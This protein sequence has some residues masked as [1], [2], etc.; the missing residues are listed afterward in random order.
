[1]ATT[2][3]EPFVVPITVAILVGLFLVQPFG[4]G[5]VGVFFGPVLALWFVTIAIL[6]VKGILEGPEV[7]AAFNPVRGIR[8]FAETGGRGFLVLGAVV[9]CLTGGEAL[10][11]DMGHFGARAIR[12]AWFALALPSLVLNYLGQGAVLLRRPE[13]VEN[14]FFFMAPG[15]ALYPLVALAAAATVIAS[16]ALISAVF[17]L[18]R[19]AMQLDFSPR[20]KI[21]HTSAEE[22][23]QIYLPGLNW[24]LMLATI[25]LVVGFGS[26]SRLAAAFGL[27]VAGTMGV[28]TALFAYVMRAH[29]RWPWAAVGVFVAVFLTIDLAFLGANGMKLMDGGWLPLVIG[30]AV[31][32]V[33]TTWNTGRRLL[34][35]CYEMKSIP[36]GEFLAGLA[37]KPVHRIPGMAVFM[38][39]TSDSTP[40]GLLHYMRHTQVLHERVTILHVATLE[41]PTV[42][43]AERVTVELLGSGVSRILARYGFAEEPNVPEILWLAVAQGFD[44]DLETT[45]FFLSR[46]T[47]IASEK[48]GMAIWREKLFGVMYRNALNPT[49][50]FDLPPER[51]VELGAQVEI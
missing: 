26:S 21:E 46:A 20:F 45:T 22:I 8:F 31:F 10:Y 2:L 44:Y 28:T 34:Y 24:A 47:V 40:V 32:T 5:R 9:L 16:Q 11:A 33:M 25:A 39:G 7:L 36:I 13:S 18:T 29:W 37:S 3:F 14:P 1:M 30:G 35:R 48:R 50:Y 38:T 15:W 43:A 41:V 6:G 23:G 12:A 51:V 19:Q 42:P 4:S 27:A 17:S 49:A